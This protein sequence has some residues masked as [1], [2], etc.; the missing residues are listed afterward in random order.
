LPFV[1]S[2]PNH[3][4]GA[5]KTNNRAENFNPQINGVHREVI[6]FT[7]FPIVN[8]RDDVKNRA[9]DKDAAEE[10]KRCEAI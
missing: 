7:L 1:F 2:A 3:K 9:Q 5:E 8:R 6:V 4:P 10:N